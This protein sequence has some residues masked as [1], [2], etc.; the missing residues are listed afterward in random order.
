[1][2]KKSN[3]NINVNRDD[4]SVNDYLICW[5]YFGERPNQ[6]IIYKTF[7]SPDFN[8]FLSKYNLENFGSF[9]EI[10]PTEEENLENQKSLLKISEGIF[11]SLTNYDSTMESG[12]IGEIT[13]FYKTSQQDEVD[14]IVEEINS[15]ENFLEEKDD[16]SE[17]H[18][19]F[20]FNFGQNGLE[21]QRTDFLQHD[22]ENV[23]LF[24]ND[25]TFKKISKTR[26]LIKKNHKGLTILYG[27]RG[28]G[29][30]SIVDYIVSDTNKNAI[31]LPC[32]LI[33]Q[34][35]NNPDFR[36]I[37]H[38]NTNSILILDDC[39][40]YFSELYSKS[41]IFTNNLLQLLDGLDS[42]KLNLN[43]VII[44]NVMNL[45]QIDHILLECNNLNDVIEF[46]KLSSTKAK[47]LAK[48]LKKKTKFKEEIRL[49]DIIKDKKSQNIK[50]DIGFL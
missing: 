48:H 15:L 21:L 31:Y 16:K 29:K 11:I 44:L 34:T 14:S 47:E 39:E 25:S 12:I 41:N 13:L 2:K 17:I 30:S 45:D 23:D 10:Y 43:I 32:N 24:Y 27:E 46:T 20:V 26:K 49:I 42:D 6:L 18:K 28:T 50:S 7:A 35:I 19:K 38:K 8:N 3:L 9:I 1:M 33:D 36:N 4:Q 37:L 5:D 40:L 22:K